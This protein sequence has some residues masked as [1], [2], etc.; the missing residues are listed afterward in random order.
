MQERAFLVNA[1]RPT[2]VGIIF[3]VLLGINTPF[4]KQVYIRA[5]YTIKKFTFKLHT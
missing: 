5:I 1:L 4:T 3:E 2:K